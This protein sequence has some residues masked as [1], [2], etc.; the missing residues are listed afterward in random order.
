MV[1]Q[2]MGTK[3]Y[4]V[5]MFSDGMDE[6]TLEKTPVVVSRQS[7]FLGLLRCNPQRICSLGCN[8]QCSNYKGV[9]ERLL[10]IL[11]C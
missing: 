2:L 3:H 11:T 6:K 5:R 9:M 10:N 1:K 7:D 4:P 8:Y